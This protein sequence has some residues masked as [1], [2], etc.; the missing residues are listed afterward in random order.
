MRQLTFKGFLRQYVREMS[1]LNTNDIK[2]LADKVPQNYR[3]IEPLILYALSENKHS[4]LKRAAKDN[5]LKQAISYFPDSIS[6]EDVVCSLEN[7]DK[8]IPYEFQ[9]TYNSYVSIRDRYKA[10]SHTKVLML[11]RTRQIQRE[12]KI[13]A[14]RVYTDLKLNHGNV[15][16]YLKNGDVN[17]VSLEVAERVLEYL[18]NI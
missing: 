15:N 14:Y 5:Q 6:W 2:R 4:H 10:K 13:S 16:D 3:L 11:N 9:K 18:E 7:H 12:K 8:D 1:N 17:K